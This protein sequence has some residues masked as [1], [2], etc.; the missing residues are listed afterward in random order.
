[1]KKIKEVVIIRYGEVGKRS[2]EVI[3]KF[4]GPKGFNK[5]SFYSLN[6]ASEFAF[7]MFR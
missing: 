4:P 6:E 2:F 1:M 5:Q 3:Q 7:N